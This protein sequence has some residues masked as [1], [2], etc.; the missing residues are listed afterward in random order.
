MSIFKQATV[1]LADGWWAPALELEGGQ[2]VRGEYKYTDRAE[3]QK[4]ADD[5][6]AK[7]TAVEIS[8]EPAT[9]EE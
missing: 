5:W 8:P 1:L 2:K 7:E 9:T 4:A 6:F 3:A